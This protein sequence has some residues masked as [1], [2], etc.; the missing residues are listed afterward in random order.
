MQTPKIY[1]YLKTHRKTGMKYL[2]KT[3]KDPFKYSGS[4]V[5]WL[6]H[7]N[8]H[9]NDVKTEIL[10]CTMSLQEFRETSLF[11]SKLWNIVESNE[12]A[13]LTEENGKGGWKKLPHSHY[14]KAANKAAEK[15]RGVKQTKEHILK[16][17]ESRKGKSSTLKGKK[18]GKYSSERIE[19]ASNGLKKSKKTCPHCGKTGGSANMSRYH[20]DNCKKILLP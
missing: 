5:Y 8:K 10:L 18:L 1:L 7:L 9:G 3:S 12:F 14:V 11:F 17:A 15:L 6:K 4:G 13:N 19:A 16:R 2:G 20:F